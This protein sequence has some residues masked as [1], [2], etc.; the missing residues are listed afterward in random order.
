MSEELSGERLRTARAYSRIQ[1]GEL[2]ARAGMSG[3]HLSRL[4]SVERK[5][6][7]PNDP[8]LIALASAAGFEVSFLFGEPLPASEGDFLFR[9][10]KT[11]RVGE[12]RAAL[13]QGILF[14]EAVDLLDERLAA[15]GAHLPLADLPSIAGIPRADIEA[16]AAACREHWRLGDTAP[17]EN[18]MRVLE[19]RGGAIA[20]RV[21]GLSSNIEAFS[22]PRGRLLVILCSTRGSGSSDRWSCA[23]ELGHLLLHQGETACEGTIQDD[24][25]RF[26]GAFLLPRDAFS[27][28]FPRDIDWKSMIAAKREVKVSLSAMLMRAFHLQIIDKQTRERAFKA[29]SAKGWTR[30]EPAEPEREHP[31]AF[32]L[33]FAELARLGY[34]AREF[35]KDLGWLP[36]TLAAVTG[37]DIGEAPNSSRNVVPLDDYRKAKGG[38]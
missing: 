17:I 9:R 10:R 38:A 32:G 8:V 25:N 16:I 15:S 27:W 37:L 11:A 35:A 22:K 24:A 26:A 1:S 28:W 18:M 30:G 7:D 2:A 33:G 3:E 13:A 20:T 36:E 5:P 4:V 23:H 29:L 12:Q 14:A 31:E 21:P 19:Q 6:A 34:T